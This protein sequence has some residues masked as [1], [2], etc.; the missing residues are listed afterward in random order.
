MA[1][2][3]S[4]GEGILEALD[5]FGKSGDIM[6][7]VA[8]RAKVVM[9]GAHSHMHLYDYDYNHILRCHRCCKVI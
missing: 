9:R 3:T 5:G 1:T 8:T 4:P 2:G 7:S 6:C